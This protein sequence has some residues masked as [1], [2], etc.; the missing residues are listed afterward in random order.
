MTFQLKP[1]EV[2]FLPTDNRRFCGYNIKLYYIFKTGLKKI[3]V[4][5]GVKRV[6]ETKSCL[7]NHKSVKGIKINVH[8]VIEQ[9]HEVFDFA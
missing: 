1:L 9:A 6:K 8:T 4:R 3:E 7:Y 5:P 2:T